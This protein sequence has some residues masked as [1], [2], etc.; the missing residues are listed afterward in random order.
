[1]GNA[2]GLRVQINTIRLGR[3]A[4]GSSGFDFRARSADH[5]KIGHAR[6]SFNAHFPRV[7]HRQI[8]VQRFLDTQ[9]LAAGISHLQFQ[10]ECRADP[11]PIIRNKFPGP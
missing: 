11:D 7:A 4:N 10:P 6:Q 2:G 1:M 8:G 9:R 5:R 3:D